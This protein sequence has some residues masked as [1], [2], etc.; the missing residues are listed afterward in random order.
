MHQPDSIVE[1]LH[2]RS[3][4]SPNECAY[5]FL[6]GEPL[7]ETAIT[8]K[9]LDLKAR[10]VAVHLQAIAQKGDRVLLLENSGLAFL[11]AFFGCLYAGLI[12]VPGY[13]PRRG[14]SVP[15]LEGMATD[16]GATAAFVKSEVIKDVDVYLRHYPKLCSLQ[17]VDI[18]SISLK[19]ADEW[20]LPKFDSGV[21]AYLQYTSGSTSQPKGVIV[22]HDNL[23]CN[24]HHFKVAHNFTP[25]SV[26]VSWL[27]P[28]HDMGLVLGLLQAVYT[29]FHCVFMAPATFAQKPIR[30]LQAISD[31]KGTHS[32]APNFAYDLCANSITEENSKGLDLKNWM[33]TV[34]GAEPVRAV[35]IDRF[36]QAFERFG[37]RRQ[38]LCPCYGLAEATLMVTFV[39]PAADAVNCWLDTKALAVNRIKETT[40]DDPC[41]RVFVGC[42]RPPQDTSVVVV[43]PQSFAICPDDEIGEIWVRG[44]T[45]AAGYWHKASETEITFG[46]CLVDTEEGNWLRTGD[47]GFLRW[48]ELFLVGRL[49][50]MIIIRGQNHYPQDIE[51]TVQGSHCALQADGVAA[52]SVEIEGEERLTVVQEVKRTALR[53]IS[54][55]EI[56]ECVQGAIHREHGIFLHQLCLVKPTTVSKTSSGKIMRGVMRQ[57]FMDNDFASV[58]SWGKKSSSQRPSAPADNG[59]S[60]IRLKG[61]TPALSIKE[62][63]E[64]LQ[65]I[66]CEVAMEALELDDTHRINPERSLIEAGLDSVA[67]V[68]M[69]EKLGGRVKC[70]LPPT[71]LFEHSTIKELTNYIACQT[72]VPGEKA[73]QG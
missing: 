13:P 19:L 26:M 5:T 30:W 35:T 23:L 69:T 34:N 55:E 57:R 2:Q 43:N 37:F 59:S 46:G 72:S 44:A 41:G 66:V 24:L 73:Y 50:E 25:E 18:D 21:P 60:T 62:T 12:A 65:N 36:T 32:A 67:A 39:S 42:G 53:N 20:V 8:Y 15:A 58:F 56:C 3:L 64:A 48:G 51:L 27:P 6:S 38:T 31:Y 9:D 54:P 1:I 33:A 11:S 71:L 22:N 49:K 63:Y 29:G 45:V 4:C 7:E 10:S 28:Y 68:A 61:I 70:S 47:L 52:F 16:A 14:R 17:M 40:P